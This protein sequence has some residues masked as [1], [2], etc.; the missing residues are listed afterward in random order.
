[1]LHAQPDRPRRSNLDQTVCA[2]SGVNLFATLAVRPSFPISDALDRG[3]V[4]RSVRL[5]L[6]R[7]HFN[8]GMSVLS[9]EWHR[10]QKISRPAGKKLNKAWL[11]RP[12]QRPVRKAG[13]ARRLPRRAA[14]KLK[15]MDETLRLFNPGDVVVDLGSAP[16]AWSQHV[17]RKCRPTAQPLQR[18]KALSSRWIC[19]PWSRLRACTL[20]RATFARRKRCR[21]SRRPWAVGRSTSWYPTWLPT[22]RHRVG[23]CRWQRVSG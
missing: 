17:R 6:C 14:Y 22:S 3:G 9:T 15:E 23:G 10:A 5:A 1:L 13:H 16:G 20:S 21:T 8:W 4:L 7:S 2:E 12:P 11:R 19:C 18:P